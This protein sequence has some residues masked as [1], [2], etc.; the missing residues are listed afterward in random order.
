MTT[1]TSAPP[2]LSTAAAVLAALDKVRDETAA[3]RV[4]GPGL[5]LDGDEWQ[6]WYTRRAELLDR[7]AACWD[8]AHQLPT[9][10]LTTSFELVLAATSRAHWA[11]R[12]AAKDLRREARRDA[13][14]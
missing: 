6:A 10:E 4:P 5:A 13:R 12:D 9:S 14:K 3:L 2:A 11:T 1:D 8:T 7:E